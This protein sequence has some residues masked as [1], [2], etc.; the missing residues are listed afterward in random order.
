MSGAIGQEVS[1]VDGRAK[2]TGAARYSGE[3]ALPG[4]AH[5]EIVGAGIAS[6]RIT[7]I[8]TTAASAPR[9]WPVSSLTSTRRR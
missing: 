5:A 1:R 8:D 6:G 3:I 4:L 7:S 2:V 9:A